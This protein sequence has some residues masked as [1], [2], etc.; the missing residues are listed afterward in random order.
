MKIF[1][2][3]LL[4]FSF[5][6]AQAE[7]LLKERIKA[8]GSVQLISVTNS[9]RTVTQKIILKEI[10]EFL[11]EHSKGITSNNDLYRES[12]IPA[13]DL[14]K[15]H[16]FFLQSMD[17]KEKHSLQNMEGLKHLEVRT[18][19][20]QGPPKN[21]I[22]LPILAEGYTLAEKDRFFA[23]AE[24]I[25]IDLFGH[26][27]FSSYLQ[28]F[29]VYAIFVASNESGVTDVQNKDT[30]FGLYRSPAGS[31]R[32]I[33][34]SNTWALERAFA[35]APG[36]DYPIVL[37]NDDYYGGL[38]GRFAITTRSLTSGSMVLRHELGHNFGNVGEEYDGG[39]VYSGANF[40]R[41]S[42]PLKWE[43][44][45]DGEKEIYETKF[46][47][48]AYL[49]KDMTR[50]DIHVNF[51]FP[52]ENYVL[53]L[54]VSSV[55]WSNEGEVETQLNGKELKLRGLYTEDRSFFFPETL[56]PLAKGK[57]RLSFYDRSKDGDNVFAFAMV[58]AQPK[59]INT[60]HRHIGGYSVFNVDRIKQ[61][62]RPTYETCIMRNM[63]SKEFCAVDQENM[64]V[65]FLNKV[66]LLDSYNVEK[67]AAGSKLSLSPA[68]PN[69]GTWT[70][71]AFNNRGN[72][73]FESP[74]QNVMNF[75]PDV[76]KVKVKFRTSEVRKYNSKFDQM[77]RIR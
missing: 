68:F 74:L 63:R 17:S 29:N 45:I 39:Y 69:H 9:K 25:T 58:Y 38:G 37:V 36:A 7:Y 47:T 34:P 43:H 61:G 30:A 77:I 60:T 67:T 31:K 6:P 44:W 76:S 13:K 19:S 46:L 53:D 28:L 33:I 49:W 48:G 12:L 41:G 15:E 1:S 71:E 10:K 16:Y 8:D 11:D 20:E 59:D 50:Q 62:Y 73:L 18:I 23:D 5:I 65:R 26:A 54:K 64:W 57:H 75:K 14:K 27:A 22:N 52:S 70:V 55:G 3:L 40:S 21:R 51:N 24:R 2:F 56:M 42:N 72:R 32:G 66:K 35:K 4:C